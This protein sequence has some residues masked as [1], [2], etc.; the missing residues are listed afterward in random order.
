MSFLMT[1]DKGVFHAKFTAVVKGKGLLHISPTT[2]ST[3]ED[4]R[5][6]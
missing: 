4:A 5:A 1:F 2:I 3:S 6:L